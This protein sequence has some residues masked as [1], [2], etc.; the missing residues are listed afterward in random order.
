MAINVERPTVSIKVLQKAF[1]IFRALGIPG[2]RFMFMPLLKW[3][4]RNH[5]WVTELSGTKNA[6]VIANAQSVMELSVLLTGY[7]EFLESVAIAR[8]MRPGFAAID[9]GANVG[10]HAIRLADAVGPSGHIFCYEP[11]PETFMRLAR[12]IELNDFSHVRAYNCGIAQ[13]KGCLT[14]YVNPPNEPNRNATMLNDPLSIGSEPIN[15][16]VVPLDHLWRTHME[17]R[18][19]D[20]IKID[21]EGY[22]IE[23]LSSGSALLAECRPVIL[24]EYSSYY[25]K[26]LGLSWLDIVDFY[27]RNGYKLHDL[28]GKVIDDNL[29]NSNAEGYDFLAIPES[30]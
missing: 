9:I 1:G 3:I 14:L 28:A 21:I 22:E 24:S 29:S 8:I 2:R 18:K 6:K 12:N 15:V 23:A 27:R 10:L 5:D 17:S 16:A 25:N 11:N 13:T 7:W 30:H 19:I 26:L 20:F 4:A